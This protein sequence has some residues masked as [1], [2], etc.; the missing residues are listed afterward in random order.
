MTLECPKGKSW[1]YVGEQWEGKGSCV[2]KTDVTITSTPT[3]SGIDAGGAYSYKAVAKDAK[4]L[5]ITYSLNNPQGLIG[6]TID[7]KTG[8]VKWTAENKN[9]GQGW[10]QVKAT[11]ST[12]IFDVQMVAVTVCVPTKKWDAKMEMCM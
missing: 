9:Y 7:G 12:G 5:P 2:A 1:Q 4:N 8:V 10:F 11:N 6:I 3:T